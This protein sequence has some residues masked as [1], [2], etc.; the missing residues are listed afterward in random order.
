MTNYSIGAS[1]KE[2]NTIQG[3]VNQEYI[4]NLLSNNT[5]LIRSYFSDIKDDFD[6]EFLDFFLNNLKIKFEINKHE[7]IY[8][9]FNQQDIIKVFKYLIFR[10]RFR[11]SG[12]K[13][14]SFKAPTYLLIEPVSTCNLRCPFCFQTD[15]SFT[16]KPYMGVMNFDL[17]KKIVDEADSL[18]IGAITIASR[19]E[20]TLHKNYKDMLKYIGEKKNIF[21]VK[22]NTNATFLNEDNCHAI[23]K[24]NISQVVISS[25]HY[26][27]EKYEKLRL[28]ANFE[29]IVE[30][31]DRLFNIRNTYYPNSITE[32]RISGIDNDRNLDRKLF[33][34]FW[35]KRSDH[36][37]ASYPMER[38]NTYEN[39]LHPEINDPCQYL[40]DRMYV[41]FDGKTNPCDADYKSYLSY[42]DVSKDTIENIWNNQKLKEIRYSHSNNERNKVDPCN[43]CGVTFI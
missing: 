31:V 6:K 4:N 30:N 35:I 7:E 11:E 26:I 27:K 8:I 9:L 17:F 21:E 40:W 38:W 42:G 41:W 24:N 23:L 10:N 13:K 1:T 3:K 39:N 33:H 14:I 20:P 28:G 18:K 12:D 2:Q 29:K 15:K 5:K 43:K 25:D 34:D 36:V 16:K 22:T 19:G 37:S 32:I